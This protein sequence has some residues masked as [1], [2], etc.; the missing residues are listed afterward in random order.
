MHKN[1]DALTEQNEAKAQ[2]AFGSLKEKIDKLESV[3][4]SLRNNPVGKISGLTSVVKVLEY[5]GDGFEDLRT[6]RT[7]LYKYSDLK[8]RYEN[9]AKSIKEINEDPASID[10]AFVAK[11]RK[12]VEEDFKSD[13]NVAEK[14]IEKY[15]ELL[16]IEQHNRQSAEEL[17][18]GYQ[19]AI[20]RL[21]KQLDTANERVR[22]LESSATVRIV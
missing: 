19:K 20:S 22:S 16:V 1:I 6:S 18:R 13:L 8:N 12:I 10:K 4:D 9:L 14:E 21:Q 17:S 3:L 15:A 5:Q 7:T 2:Q 11:V